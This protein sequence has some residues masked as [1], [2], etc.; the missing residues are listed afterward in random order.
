MIWG[1]WEVTPKKITDKYICIRDKQINKH[2]IDIAELKIRADVKEERIR[3]VKDEISGIGRKLDNVNDKLD[4]WQHHSEQ[5]DAV[6]SNRLV[7]LE[8]TQTVIKWIV[9]LSLPIITTAIAI[10]YFL[11]K[12][13]H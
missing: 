9:G 10:I 1:R 2:E 13:I 7:K 8:N 6:M 3:E 12:I 5:D 11:M 4:G